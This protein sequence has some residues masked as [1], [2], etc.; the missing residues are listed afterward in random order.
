MLE[1]LMALAVITLTFGGVA[2]LVFQ[3]DKNILAAETKSHNMWLASSALES[4]SS[5]V[6]SLSLDSYTKLVTSTIGDVSFSRL[7]VDWTTALQ[8]RQCQVGQQDWV[9]VAS[10]SMGYNF[11]PISSLIVNGQIMVVA[12]AF[13]VLKTDPTLLLFNL[14]SSTNPVL[15]GSLDNATGTVA[16]LNAVI[17]A[18]NYIYAAS[19]RAISASQSFGQ[20]QIIDISS[21][22]A[23]KLISTYKLPGVSGTS[24]QGIG[25]S[26]F[27]HQG[28]IYLGLTKTGSGPEFSVIDVRDVLHPQLAGAFGLGNTVNAIWVSGGYAYLAHPA[29][30]SSLYNEQLTVLD[31]RD[32][33]NISR[34]N[35]FRANDEQ[36]NGKSLW[37]NGDELFLGRTF[38]N[39]ANPELQVFN[40]SNSA[41]INL[42]SG[43]KISSSVN[44]LM[45]N[46]QKLFVTTNS[47]IR[48]FN[49]ADPT[50]ITELPGSINLPN[51]AAG[52]SLDCSGK[53]LYAGSDTSNKGYLLILTSNDN[54]Q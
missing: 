17:V 34:V 6:K 9:E 33:F 35:G 48:I 44:S 31:V 20:L 15:V 16:G 39:T 3:N 36:G 22:L 49:I 12:L 45:S 29:D 54:A 24:G 32:P 37:Q 40:S 50:R 41:I 11:G 13:T 30:A 52:S 7:V 1:A 8:D 23:P 10:S 2:A 43:V 38:T 53:T 19:A 4:A 5:T 25:S 46:G 51:G 14:A 26:I 21:P 27:Y 42:L 47:G 28:Y 18:G